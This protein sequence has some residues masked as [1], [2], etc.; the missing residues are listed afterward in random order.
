MLIG[1]IGAAALL[2]LVSFNSVVGSN[3]EKLSIENKHISPLFTVR[4]DRKLNRAIIQ[5]STSNYIGKGRWSNL[6]P[7]TEKTLKV[8]IEKA[9]HLIETNP[10]LIYVILNKAS[11][12]PAVDKILNKN[13]IEIKD[14]KDQLN[15]LNKNPEIIKEELSKIAQEHDIPIPDPEPQGLSTSSAIGCFIIAVFAFLPLAL[16]LGIIIGTITIATCF[17][18]GCLEAVVENLFN[19][20]IQGLT[21]PN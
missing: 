8:W 21:P 6:F 17:V 5:E 13:G 3:T 14:F 10:A 16:I 19:S 20:M 9:I 7:T 4:T 15:Q 18:P 12:V 11:K 1:C 2:V